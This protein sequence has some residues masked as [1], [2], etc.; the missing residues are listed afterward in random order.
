MEVFME[1]PVFLLDLLTA[2]ESAQIQCRRN[3]RT[4][5][6]SLPVPGRGRTSPLL[7]FD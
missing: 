4:L 2:H 7:E 6:Q 1:S 3:V 5:E